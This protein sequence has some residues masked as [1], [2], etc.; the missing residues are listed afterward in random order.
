M[1]RI[2]RYLA[3]CL[4]SQDVRAQLQSLHQLG[5]QILATF[6][7]VKAELGQIKT[8]V[9]ALQQAI[10]DLKAAGASAVTQAQLDELDAAAKDILAA[11]APSA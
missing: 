10:A 4:S 8:G 11:E 2:T 1:K 3:P 5:V 6:D 9:L 7:D